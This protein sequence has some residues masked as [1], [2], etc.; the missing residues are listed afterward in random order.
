[1]AVYTKNKCVTSSCTIHI[2]I[3][4]VG[5]HSRIGVIH[6]LGKTKPGVVKGKDHGPFLRCIS[7]EFLVVGSF[8]SCVIE[9]VLE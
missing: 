7:E 3:R 1:V 6:S 8:I 4:Y 5:C 2:Q 9:A